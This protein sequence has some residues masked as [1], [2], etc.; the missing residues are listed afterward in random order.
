MLSRRAFVSLA[1]QAAARRPNIVVIL[2]DDHGYADVSCYPH[3]PEVSTPNIDRIARSGVRFEQGYAA[4]YVCA[5]TRASIMIGRYQ[6]RCGF[7]TASDS[8]VG[9]PLS[10]VTLPDLL[11][12]QGYAT[13]AI[14]KWHL[15]ITPDYHPLKRGFDEFYGFLGHGAHDYFDLAPA[16]D[17]HQSIWRNDKVVSD[18]GYLTDNLGR[19]AS[20]FIQRNRS[21]P[22]F[23]YLAFNAVHA[24]MQA[25]DADIAKHNTGDRKRDTY[26]AMLAREDAAVG[27]VLDTLR[28]SGLE[29]NTLI[30]FL[31]DNG[32]AKANSSSNG[33]L[34][35]YKQSVYEGGVR[36]PFLM[37]WPGKIQPGGVSR[38][39]VMSF[40]IFPT[41][42]RA[43]GAKLP[44]DRVLD[45]RDIMTA[46][47]GRATG[48]LH[49]SLVWDGHE[50]RWAVRRGK[51]KLVASGASRELYDMDA[52]PGEKSDMAAKEPATVKALATVYAS[53]R[54]QMK[55]RIG[56]GPAGQ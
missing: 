30:V 17:A 48:P 38:E 29:Q 31:S 9:L 23:L 50:D 51:W 28:D 12:K 16:A 3:G 11:R 20:A 56:R 41:A 55:P 6:Q 21:R 44:T 25:P 47:N 52:D 49:D 27:R 26:L 4:A 36:V 24:P 14:G 7:Y 32:G 10:E 37:S 53:W 33:A 35:D 1:A 42:C 13:A 45:G 19:E 8:R 18:T 46:L 22:F 15:G 39:P 2:S 34:R 43:A 5:P 40:D 54:R